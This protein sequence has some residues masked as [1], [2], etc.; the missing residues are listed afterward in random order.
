MGEKS[1]KFNL[2]AYIGLHHA[3]VLLWVF[4]GGRDTTD[5]IIEDAETLLVAFRS[6]KTR[7]RLF[8]N[9]LSSFT[10][11]LAQVNGRHLHKLQLP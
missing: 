1:V 2:L 7:V 11:R 5:T 6:L 10:R 3:A 4:A 9:R 8:W